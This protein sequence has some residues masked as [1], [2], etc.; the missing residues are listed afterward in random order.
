MRRRMYLLR[1]RS[2]P[3]LTPDESKYRGYLAGALH[4]WRDPSTT[5]VGSLTHGVV[6]SNA[7]NA[8]IDT[9]LALFLAGG[10]VRSFAEAVAK[11]RDSNT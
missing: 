3:A 7:L 9:A 4:E 8:E 10:K 2:L 6:A 11:A 1:A 5:I